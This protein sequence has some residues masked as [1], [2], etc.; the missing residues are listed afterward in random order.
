[1][2]GSEGEEANEISKRSKST[3]S[4]QDEQQDQDYDEH[5]EQEEQ[6]QSLETDPS[7]NPFI[8]PNPPLSPSSL[9]IANP[10]PGRSRRS[11]ILFKKRQYR[12]SI[13]SPLI[14]S[15]TTITSESE[16]DNPL[17]LKFKLCQRNGLPVNTSIL[18][19]P[20]E[21][22]DIDNKSNS[23]I[24]DQDM[25]DETD[26]PKSL[27]NSSYN[28][29]LI[30][31]ERNNES[32]EK[33]YHRMNGETHSET[34]DDIIE[35]PKSVD[36]VDSAF[37]GH[38]AFSHPFD[39]PRRNRTYTSSSA[40]SDSEGPFRRTVSGHKRGRRP[41]KKLYSFSDDFGSLEEIEG[42]KSGIYFLGSEN[43]AGEDLK[44]PKK[45]PEILN[46][47]DLVWAKCRG[48]PSYPALVGSP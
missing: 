42:I 3:V 48:Y 15:E 5:E 20:T 34:S 32:M 38:F 28:E 30:S 9:T 11:G 33:S 1:M 12:P 45:D 10:S 13:N 24:N 39:P 6:E 44:D 18:I 21:K 37:E 26:N 19:S 23:I 14:S 8:L 22:M 36:S 2:S 43:L 4:E 41:F 46:P 27:L 40:N 31:H 17:K 47:L 16:D 29:S 25:K 35:N 7:S